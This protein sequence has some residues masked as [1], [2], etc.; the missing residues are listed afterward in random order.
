MSLH[1]QI[2]IGALIVGF[3]SQLI[4]IFYM[5]KRIARLEKSNTFL[6]QLCGDILRIFREMSELVDKMNKR[7]L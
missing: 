7:D 2:A 6:H 5:Q 4:S 1:M 3:G